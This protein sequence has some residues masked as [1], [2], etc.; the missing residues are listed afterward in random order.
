MVTCYDAS[1]ARIIAHAELDCVLVGDSLGMVVQGRESTLP[2][3]LD[4]IIYHTNMV[5][6]GAKD[7][8]II[9]DLPFMSY[10]SSVG[11][12]IS[13]A[14]RIMKE[15]SADAVKLEGA[16]DFNLSVI[17]RLREI[18]IPVMGHLG[19]TPQSFHVLGGYKV[20]GKSKEDQEKLIRDALNLEAA[21]AFSVVLEMVPANVAKE[22][23]TQ[24]QI[25]TIGIGAG[26]YVDGQVLVL[27]DLL[28]MNPEFTPKFLKKYMNLYQT[29]LESM[30]QY[31]RDVETE[32][33]PNEENSF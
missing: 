26:K 31:K 32:T 8:P 22:I 21:G 20:Q 2:V 5:R 30:K 3:T 7:I 19:L 28:G 6:R 23:T 18:G 1:F 11:D 14:G 15:T 17:H 29:I 10:H 27:Y 12:A 13:S 33:F 16:S 25:P 24:L 4:E 9:S